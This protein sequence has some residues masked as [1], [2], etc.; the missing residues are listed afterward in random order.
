M[1]DIDNKLAMSLTAETTAL[2]PFIPYMLQDL[3]E[4]GSSPRDIERL[5]TEHIANPGELTV[6]DLG[7]GKGAVSVHLAMK[8]GYRVTGIDL[9]QEFIDY[10]QKKAEEFG[11]A[12][13]C[14]FFVDDINEAVL[15]E[16]GYDVVILGS[17]GDAL[18]EPVETILKLKQTVKPGGHIII[19]DAY[20]R[21]GAESES[22][23]YEEWLELFEETGVALVDDTPVDD[24]E[25]AALN[26]E[27]QGQIRMRADELKQKHPD[28]AHLFDGYVASQQA[29]CEQLA[30]EII[31]IT[32]LLK[33]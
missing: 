18:G 28:K 26:E 1:H 22:P 31:G 30:E 11:V 19:D 14:C 10:A 16:Q 15:S 24:A 3:W 23:S 27:Q 29:E 6:L 9:I 20:R 13:R 25:L 8:L 33:T 12:H 7:C 32:W 2:I 21:P 4:L 17:V 5:I